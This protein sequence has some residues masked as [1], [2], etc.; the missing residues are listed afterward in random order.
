L[1]RLTP[2]LPAQDAI[3]LIILSFMLA[4][5]LSPVTGQLDVVVYPSDAESVDMLE[6]KDFVRSLLE[7]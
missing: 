3:R 4:S 1:S 5:R 2:V 7:P 6:L